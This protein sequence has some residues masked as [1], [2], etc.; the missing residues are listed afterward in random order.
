MTKKNKKLKDSESGLPVT[1]ADV[2]IVDFENPPVVEVVFGFGFDNQPNFSTP[3]MGLYWSKIR[4]EF[5]NIQ[6]VS[7]LG[8]PGPGT[9]VILTDLPPAPR[10]LMRRKDGKEIVQV[11][12]SWFL[13]NWVKTGKDDRYPRYDKLADR[14]HSL[15][16]SFEKF[17]SEEGYR[18]LEPVELR[19]TYVNRI[20]KG[21]GLN[22]PEEIGNIFPDFKYRNA[23][24]RF[25]S[26]PSGF[27]F[28]MTHPIKAAESRLQV[29]IRTDHAVSEDGKQNEP[30][31]RL[32]LTAIGKP[33]DSSQK[34]I[35]EWFDLARMWI[36]NGFLDLTDPKIQQN[37][38]RL[39][40][41]S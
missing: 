19:L 10:Y 17:M 14:F 41:R 36:V 20:P 7:P 39:H 32:E 34:S 5:P 23:K 2:R 4:D 31:V 29:S 40:G 38:W 6:I 25:L 16:G 26:P 22:A 30:I 27:S 37:V 21:E 18:K 13:L 12:E 35:K 15:R 1:G 11:Q 24:R 28:S 3:Q 9:K 33:G 8:R